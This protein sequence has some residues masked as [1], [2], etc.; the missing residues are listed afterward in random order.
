MALIDDRGRLFGWLNL[1]DAAV[2]LLAVAAAGLVL[3]GYALFR[4]PAPPVVTSVSP[5]RIPAN[6]EHSLSLKGRNFRPFL[7]AYLGRTGDA[8]FVRRPTPEEKQDEFTLT[9]ATR[10]QFLLE[11]PTLAEVKVPPLGVG[12][13]DLHFYD[14]TGHVAAVDGAFQVMPQESTGPGTATLIAAGAF[15]GLTADEAKIVRPGER[16]SSGDLAW[17]DVLGVGPSRPD[18]AHIAVLDRVIPTQVNG[19]YQVPA[20]LRVHCRVVG[21]ECRVENVPV[22]PGRE[23]RVIVGPHTTTFRIDSVGPDAPESETTAK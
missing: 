6:E 14:E 10:V 7:R 21:N 19:L 11:T 23:L 13:Y 1:I 15:R 3:A 5:N 18:E 8:D 2:A 22:V 4:L 9:N 12:R 17:G 20:T 16:V